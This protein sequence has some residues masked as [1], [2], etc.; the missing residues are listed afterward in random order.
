MK[1]CMDALEIKNQDIANEKEKHQLYNTWLKSIFKDPSQVTCL[2]LEQYAE[3]LDTRPNTENSIKLLN[4]L[5]D[6]LTNPF[7]DPRFKMGVLDDI[8]LFY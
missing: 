8:E 7:R 6:E 3:F 2:D 4:F 5:K 1:I